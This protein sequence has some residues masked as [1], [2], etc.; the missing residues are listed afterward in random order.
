MSLFSNDCPA[1]EEIKEDVAKK[2]LD[3][4]TQKYIG[5]PICIKGGL[6]NTWCANLFGEHELL[7]GEPAVNHNVTSQ[8]EIVRSMMSPAMLFTIHVVISILLNNSELVITTMNTVVCKSASSP[9]ILVDNRAKVTVKVDVSGAVGVADH[10]G[11][12]IVDPGH[13]LLS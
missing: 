12:Q 11:H 1:V 4:N 10:H 13:H 9:F 6:C 5:G 8:A 7:L 3:T 2:T